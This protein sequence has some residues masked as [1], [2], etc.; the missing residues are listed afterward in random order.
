[1]LRNC[2]RIFI[3]LFSI[4][5]LCSCST[6]RDP[7]KVSEDTE[8]SIKTAKINA[9]LG[10]T[11]LEHNEVLRAKHKLLIA[12]KQ[13]PDIPEPWYSMG[14]F[15]EATGNKE[16]ARKY[17]MKAIEIAPERGDVQN[18]FGTYLCRIGHYDEALT[19]FDLAVGDPNYLGP[20]D[21]YENAGLCALKIPRY[22]QAIDY[23]DH[24]VM[25]DPVRPVSL[26]K[27]AEAYYSLGHYKIAKKKLDQFLIISPPTSQSLLLS[28]QLNK[29]LA[30]SNHAQKIQNETNGGNDVK[31]YAFSSIK[32]TRLPAEDQIDPTAERV[33]KADQKSLAHE[34][35][36]EKKFVSEH[37]DDHNLA[38]EHRVDK[39]FVSEHKVDKKVVAQLK[40]KAVPTVDNQITTQTVNQKNRNPTIISY[41]DV[42]KK[43]MK[44][45]NDIPVTKKTANNVSSNTDHKKNTLTNKSK[46]I[47]AKNTDKMNERVQILN[48]LKN[49]KKNLD[50]ELAKKFQH[51]RFLATSAKSSGVK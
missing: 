11:Y 37:K 16:Q 3:L 10:I 42:L 22:R 47:Q 40:T 12:L 46:T 20:A 19:H 23:F 49:L 31:V 36:V 14:Y 29:K 1:M 21:A 38:Y 51:Q 8:R 39:K 35:K 34:Q 17:Y 26:I 33:H 30:K 18:N 6:N 15:M 7:T 9:Q 2:C 13:A 50:E 5:F 4:H 41:A 27:M 48:R 25:Q 43:Q 45:S 28:I 32:E 44:A 24:A